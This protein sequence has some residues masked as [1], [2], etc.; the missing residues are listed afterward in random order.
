MDS[1]LLSNTQ[2]SL[3]DDTQRNGLKKRISEL[4][5]INEN[6]RSEID[7]LKRYLSSLVKMQVLI[8]FCLQD[9]QR[10]TI[11][12]LRKE[13]NSFISSEIDKLDENTDHKFSLQLS[14]NKRLQNHIQNQRKAYDEMK[15]NFD[16]LSKRLADVEQE[17]EP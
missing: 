7:E 4:E 12:A 15:E 1:T 5:I 13:L 6:Q 9:D 11:E 16:Q 3:M 10:S 2:T 14:E 8:N 17:L